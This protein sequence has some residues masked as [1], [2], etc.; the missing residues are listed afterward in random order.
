MKRLQAAALAA[1]L[2]LGLAGCGGKGAGQAAPTAS[3]TEAPTPSPTPTP[4]PVSNPLTGQPG[5]FANKRP[6]AVAIRTGDGVSPQWGVANAD[7]LIEGV[8]EGPTA[9]LTAVFSS[10][11]AVSKAGPVAA[12]RDLALQMVL[13]LNA[14][15]VHINKNVYASNLLNVM[16]YQDL[17]GYHIGTAAFAFDEGRYE[18]GFREEN[19]WYTTADLIRGGL[20][21]YE[22]DTAGNNMPLF[23]FAQRP[24]PAARNATDLTI[25]FSGTD[26][27]QIVYA[28]D[29]GLYLKNNAD[30]TPQTDADSGNQAAFTNV[31]VLYAS[32][33]VKDDGITRQYDLNGGTGLY[34]TGG[35]WEQINWTKGDATA[36]LALTDA[37]GATL[38]VNPGKSFIAV[39]GGYYGQ[40]LRLLGEDGAEQALPAK[41]ALLA[42]GIPDEAAAEAE[43]AERVRL[44]ILD[45]QTALD[46]AKADLELALQAQT[47]AAAT[48][49]PED[50]AAAAEAVAAAQAA[51]DT[52]QAALDTLQPPAEE[53]AAEAPA[54]EQ[55]AE[56]APAEPPAEAPPAA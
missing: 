46:T 3:P 6:V 20:A 24:A 22:K 10:V 27:E 52:A 48:E 18:S 50:D 7:V 31:L 32:S 2:L 49:A 33:G 54:E 1:L 11:D 35:A 55:P 28:A 21:Q 16:Q 41:P 5:D 39:W 4:V 23:Y 42:S 34:L 44:E 26:S 29:A 47:D 36:P 8:S 40:G 17:D 12:G 19:C 45:A 15:P 25:T 43:E 56:P 51:V 13:P 38:Q 30:G 9:G 53:A 37:A 14:I